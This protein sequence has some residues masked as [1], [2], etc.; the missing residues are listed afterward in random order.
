MWPTVPEKGKQWVADLT[1]QFIGSQRI[2]YT[3]TNIGLYILDERS[4]NYVMLNGQ[5][6]RHTSE[7]FSAYIGVENATNFET[8]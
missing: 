3:G 7:K 8:V 2:P 1:T 4:Q 5:I 6:T